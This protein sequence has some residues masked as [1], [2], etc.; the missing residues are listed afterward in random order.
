[1]ITKF[2]KILFVFVFVNLIFCPVFVSA[3]T[4]FKEWE[5]EDNNLEQ[6]VI[7]LKL[8]LGETVSKNVKK[9]VIEGD[10]K[11]D[12]NDEIYDYTKTTIT[13]RVAT[14]IASKLNVKVIENYSE[15]KSVRPVYD[16]NKKELYLG[17]FDDPDKVQ[18][19]ANGPDGYDYQFVGMG[20][21]S[22]Q[23]LSYANVV[24]KKDE[25]GKSLKDKNGEYIIE[26]LVISGTTVTSGGEP[27]T[28]LNSIYDQRSYL[29]GAQFLLKNKDGNVAYGYCID[30]ATPAEDGTWYQ[31]QNLEDN[32]YY[33]S[34]D[35]EKHV[36][37]I[38]MN[39]YWGTESDADNDGKYDVGSLALLKQKLK[40]ALADGKIDK[41]ITVTYRENG[42]IVTEDV[43]LTNE[44]L[45]NLTEGE[46]LDMTQAAIWSYANG[47]QDVQDGKD[48]IVV[49]NVMYGDMAQGNRTGKND[50]EGMARMSA[51]YKWLLNLD[52]KAESTVVINEKNYIKGLSLSIG[53]RVKD[54]IYEA[55]VVVDLYHD[56]S[57]KDNL[58]IYLTYVDANGEEQTVVKRLVGELKEGEEYAEINENGIVIDGLQLK[59]NSDTTIS[60]RMEGYQYLELGAYIFTSEVGVE[61]SQTFVSLAEGVHNINI[62]KDISLSFD[63]NDDNKF[64]EERN[65]KT[66]TYEEYP[67]NTGIE[68]DERYT[69]QNVMFILDELLNY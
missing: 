31:I 43:E 58:A 19:S 51:L 7:T 28:D 20:D 24:Y 26:K 40:K 18:V 4:S 66:K 35:A 68:L 8:K 33:A 46:A 2:S 56:I 16:A 57:K 25:N 10:V 21:Y 9:T 30:L 34:D 64:E 67:P 62:N 44:I 63:V 48:G 42:V 23:Y 65:W 32:D 15:L 69:C 29:R 38:V 45:D 49:G 3:E 60:L 37:A 59:N 55:S 14:A 13:E 41:K 27:T 5:E 6:P 12:S 11:E 17:Y 50:P 52:T 1:M 61:G 53:N 36:R 54:D 47:A 22:S 39:G